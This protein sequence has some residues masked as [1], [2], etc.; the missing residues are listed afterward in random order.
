MRKDDEWGFKRYELKYDPFFR[1]KVNA[2]EAICMNWRWGNIHWEKLE[3][4]HLSD[5]VL[6]GVPTL[7][8]LG[9]NLTPIEEQA[10]YLLKHYVWQIYRGLDPDEPQEPASPPK[11]ILGH[12]SI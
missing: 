2:I 7:E 12:Y 10:P 4:D 1:M 11:P 9:V 5:D 3:R 8:D 6:A